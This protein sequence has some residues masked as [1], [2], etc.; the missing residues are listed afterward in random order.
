MFNKECKLTK[1]DKH[2]S[3]AKTRTMVGWQQNEQADTE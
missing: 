3:R 1:T 2:K